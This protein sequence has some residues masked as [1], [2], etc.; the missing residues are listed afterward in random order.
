MSA[1]FGT[2]TIGMALVA[3]YLGEHVFDIIIRISGAFLG[4]LLGLFVLGAAVRRANAQGALIGLGAGILSLV[5]IFPTD[6]NAWWY[7]A[8]TCIPTLAVGAGASL[9]FPAP[10]ADKVQGLLLGDHQGIKKIEEG[11]E[12]GR[13]LANHT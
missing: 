12:T 11:V 1:A 5:M 8:F 9:L 6:I 10:P 3:P 13:S 7:G 2:A 4:P